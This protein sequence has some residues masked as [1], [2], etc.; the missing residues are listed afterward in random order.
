M[1]TEQVKKIIVTYD[2]ITNEYTEREA[3]DEELDNWPKPF[4]TA[5]IE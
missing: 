2:V 4:A 5:V 3:T 1:D